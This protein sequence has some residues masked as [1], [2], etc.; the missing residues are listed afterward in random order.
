M[1]MLTRYWAETFR[2]GGMNEQGN[3]FETGIATGRA[4]CRCCGEFIT[5]GEEALVGWFD[6]TGN[7][8]SWTSQRIWLH[9]HDCGAKS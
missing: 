4:R 3:G 7:Y 6:F 9:P 1:N 8:G 2:N 5:K